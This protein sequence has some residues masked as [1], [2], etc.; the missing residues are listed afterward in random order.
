MKYIK[1]ALAGGYH[2]QE[3][4]IASI[5]DR[6]LQL[7]DK[8]QKYGTQIVKSKKGKYKQYKIDNS[9]SDKERIRIGL[10]KLKD[11][12]KYLER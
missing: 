3:W 10:P 11:L 4:L 9:I 6:L 5:N 2:K 1:E 8:P 7:Q 12:K